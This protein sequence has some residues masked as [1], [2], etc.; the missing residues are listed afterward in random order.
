MLNHVGGGK[1]RAHG[2]QR[3]SV[4]YLDQYLLPVYVRRHG[5]VIVPHEGFD[6][7]TPS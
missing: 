7:A 4:A 2:V 6:E 3:H 1:E 5:W